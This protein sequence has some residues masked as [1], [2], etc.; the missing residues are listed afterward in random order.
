M[1]L[2]NLLR[3]ARLPALAAGIAL[4]GAV[5]LRAAESAPPSAVVAADGSGQFPT[6]QAAIDA[7]PQLG[8]PSPP[9]II[10]IKPGTY[11]ERVYVQ[12]EKR[13]VRL[14]GDD[15]ARTVISYDLYASVPGPD[16]KRIGTFQTPTVWIDA[17]Q[18]AVENL[19]IANTAGPKGQALALRVDGDRVVFRNCRFLGWQDTILGNRGRHY[20]DRCAVSG[21][22]DFIFGAATEFFDSCQIRCT[23]T[24]FIT[25]ASTPADSPFGF[26]FRDCEIEGGAPG[27]QTYL[28]RPWRAFASV[29]FVNCHMGGVVRPAGWHNW[30][31]PDR[32]KTSRFAEYGSTGPGALSAARVPW[33]RPLSAAGAAALTVDRVLAGAD[34][35][36]PAGPPAPQ[37]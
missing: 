19:T 21:A 5:C 9:W 24:G 7:A 6:V 8:S 4:L 37:R 29:A 15:P 27:V 18:F 13:F 2:P 14:L 33:A 32:E 35:W 23:G 3:P 26:V 12:R 10:R 11:R 31:K 1:H 22:V 34:G 36:N 28:G 30:N 16:G 25:A 17:D 20:F